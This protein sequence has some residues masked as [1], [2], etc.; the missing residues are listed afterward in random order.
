MAK[1]GF[2]LDGTLDKE[3]IRQLANFLFDH[4]EEVHVISGFLPG[5]TYT[6]Q[7]KRDKLQRLGIRCTELHLCAGETMEEMG[8]AKAQVLRRLDIRLMVDD[9]P[10]FVRQMKYY[11][12]SDI[13][14]VL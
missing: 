8:Y 12:T 11:S 6:A 3:P 4:G 9:D 7:G 5:G 13:L 1:W 2:D 14:L 10:T